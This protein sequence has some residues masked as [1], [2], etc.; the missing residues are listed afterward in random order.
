ME[1]WH[2]CPRSQMVA[3]AMAQG[4]SASDPAIKF[5]DVFLGSASLPLHPLLNKPQV[6]QQPPL[7]TRQVHTPKQAPPFSSEEA[8]GTSPRQAPQ[9][10]V[11]LEE[12]I[13]CMAHCCGWHSI[14][15]MSSRQACLL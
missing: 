7:S 2:H 5:R 4:G 6:F 11:F 14:E 10:L 13:G 9:C 8:S 3:T 12:E 15:R 1:V